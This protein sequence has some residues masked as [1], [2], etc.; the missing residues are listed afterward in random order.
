[1][2]MLLL[3][4]LM[5]MMMMMLMMMMVVLRRKM[6]SCVKEVEKIK[7]RRT[8]RRAAQ[9]AIREHNVQQYDV[10]VPSWEFEAM[11]RYASALMCPAPPRTVLFVNTIRIGL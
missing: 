8:E 2:M 5:M 10:T 4:L 7:Q 9:T 3:L 6:S 11:I 1:M